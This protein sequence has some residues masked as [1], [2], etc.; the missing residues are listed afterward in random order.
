MQSVTKTYISD[1]MIH[2]LAEKAFPGCETAEVRELT[3][4][5]FNTAYYVRGSGALADGVILKIGPAEGV[6]V[7]TYEK[8]ILRTEVAVCRML[9]EKDVP[10]PVVLYAD[11]SHADIPCDY[12]FMDY[13]QGILWK[14]ADEEKMKVCR[15]QLME[16]LGHIHSEI[17]S[18]MGDWFG[19]IKDDEHFRHDSWYKA[20]TSMMEDICNDG[21]KDALDLPYE[22]ILALV[23]KHRAALEEVTES[24][25]VDFDMWAGNVIL[26]EDES[27]YR[28]N[29]IIDFERCF[30]GDPC[31]DFISSVMIFDDVAK[32]P[33]FLKGYGELA[34]DKN[35]ETRMTLYRLYLGVIMY[36]ETYRFEEEYAEGTKAWCGKYIAE[37]MEKL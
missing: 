10:A 15:P 28:I 13:K 5:M 18:V 33:E 27:G 6:K 26:A 30:F 21:K 1:E 36:V 16:A 37:L 23:E 34:L 14:D 4:G 35:T 24:H 19:Y 20:F 2:R 32:E 22:E 7:L 9:Q 12:F 17:H 31:G 8:N 29:G 11:Y 25:L 3:E